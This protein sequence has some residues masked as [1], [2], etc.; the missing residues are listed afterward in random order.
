MVVVSHWLSCG[1]FLL[2][3]FVAGLGGV[4]QPL[5]PGLQLRNGGT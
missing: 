3:E 1:A 4:G 5:R 2:G